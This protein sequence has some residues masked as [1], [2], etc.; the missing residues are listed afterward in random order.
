[1]ENREAFQSTSENCE[2]FN[3]ESSV[4]EMRY[5][6][7][8]IDAGFTECIQN[9]SLLR[10]DDRFQMMIDTNTYVYPQFDIDTLYRVY[11]LETLLEL[12]PY[13]LAILSATLGGKGAQEAI[14]KE[15][16]YA[17]ML[18]ELKKSAVKAMSDI[19]AMLN[20]A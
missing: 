9:T 17:K 1:M 16:T 2:E 5:G 18:A 6:R 4:S 8:P 20:M 3:G 10:E 14:A 11:E 7:P 12:L 15:P 19:Q 13:H